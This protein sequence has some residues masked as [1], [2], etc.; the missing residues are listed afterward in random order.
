MSSA[1]EERE[2]AFGAKQVEVGPVAVVEVPS[3]TSPVLQVKVRSSD[4]GSSPS[5]E[6]GSASPAP[7]TKKSPP[8]KV[9]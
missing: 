1:A 6:S 9:I 4:P 7:T 8:G 2:D 3:L 5:A